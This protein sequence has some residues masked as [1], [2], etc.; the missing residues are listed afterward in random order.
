MNGQ[1]EKNVMKGFYCMK[2]LVNKLDKLF[3]I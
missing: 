2:N 3:K 1:Q